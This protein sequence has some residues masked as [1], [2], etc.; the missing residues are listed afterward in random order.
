[1]DS[2]DS[3]PS[4]SENHVPTPPKT[5]SAASSPRPT[6]TPKQPPQVKPSSSKEPELPTADRRT[7]SQSQPSVAQPKL[8]SSSNA[9]SELAE[10]KAAPKKALQQLPDVAADAE[11]S[12]QSRDESV[13]RQHQSENAQADMPKQQQAQASS[14]EGRTA[15]P[16]LP[17]PEADATAADERLDPQSSG[18][19]AGPLLEEGEPALS[20]RAVPEKQAAAD[21]GTPS[22]IQPT[23]SERAE[24]RAHPLGAC[25]EATAAEQPS[26]A[27]KVQEQESSARVREVEQESEPAEQSGEKPPPLISD[28]G[29]GQPSRGVEAGMQS[30]EPPFREK[31]SASHDSMLAASAVEDGQTAEAG[32]NSEAPA[33]SDRTK[34]A[35]PQQTAQSGDLHSAPE[36]LPTR[37]ESAKDSNQKLHAQQPAEDHPKPSS[38][39]QPLDSETQEEAAVT[40]GPSVSAAANPL[41]E[42]WRPSGEE[43]TAQPPETEATGSI[44]EAALDKTLAG[45]SGGRSLVTSPSTGAETAG[46]AADMGVS[47]SAEAEPVVSSKPGPS[48]PPLSSSTLEAERARPPLEVPLLGTTV[49]SSSGDRGQDKAH[50]PGLERLDGGREAQ[51]S[52]VDYGLA[53][54]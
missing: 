43:Q 46:A 42:K 41:Q 44:H 37:D 49:V 23:F 22:T 9:E 45:S 39:A 30:A 14:P 50:I 20:A 26:T 8:Q 40:S 35:Q 33:P 28:P 2:L 51:G 12:S 29:V 19:A 27:G 25:G 47:S 3:Q 13:Q 7:V 16:L 54:R 38:E 18:L 52:S 24:E 1:M 31:L 5:Y 11:P 36:D 4:F 10:G 17:P 48:E 34:I 32:V 6:L 53:S 21:Q 15:E